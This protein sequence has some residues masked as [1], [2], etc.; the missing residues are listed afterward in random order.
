MVEQ[1][2]DSHTEQ[3]HEDVVVDNLDADVSV[4]GSGNQ[5]TCYRTE[6]ASLATYHVNECDQLRTDDG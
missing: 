6:L 3:L 2:R 1:E 5:T 4:Q